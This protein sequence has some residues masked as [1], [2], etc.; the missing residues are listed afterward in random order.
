MSEAASLQ[1]EHHG[2]A[3]RRVLAGR[4]RELAMLRACAASARDGSGALAL[5]G[6]EAGVGKTALVE[7]ALCAGPRERPLTILTARAVEAGGSRLGLW[8]DLLEPASSAET[9]PWRSESPAVGDWLASAARRRP[10]AIVLEDLQWADRDSLAMLGRLAARADDLPLLL[11]G[12]YRTDEPAAELSELLPTLVHEAR[13]RRVALRPLDPAELRELVR[14]HRAM[15]DEDESRLVDHLHRRTGGNPLLALEVLHAL[16][17]DGILRETGCGGWE[18]GSLGGESLPAVVRQ[19]VERRV[20]RLGDDARALLPVA[21]VLGREVWLTHWQAVTE[22]SPDV[23]GA[24]IERAT[25][26][27]VLVE[28]GEGPELRFASE[29]VHE[30]LYHGVPLP[31]RRSWHQRAAEILARMPAPPSDLVAHHFRQARDPRAL[32]WFVRGA[33]TAQRARA[34]RDA[35]ARYR[36]A[37][38]LVDHGTVDPGERTRLLVRLG[39]ADHHVDPAAALPVLDECLRRA[40]PDPCRPMA[41]AARYARGVAAAAAGRTPTGVT[42][43]RAVVRALP[44]G[45]DREGRWRDAADCLGPDGSELPAPAARLALVLATAGAHAEA[46][47]LAEHLGEGAGASSPRSRADAE[48][49]RAEIAAARGHPGPAGRGY[50]EAARLRLDAGDW[51]GAA[52]AMLHGLWHLGLLYYADRPGLA[53]CS[54]A[55]AEATLARVEPAAGAVPPRFAHLPL[56]VISGAWQQAIELAPLGTARGSVFAE[57]GLLAQAAMAAARGEPA[58]AWAVVQE[59]LPDGVETEPGEAPALLAVRALGLGAGLALEA[60]DTIVA[61]EWI[62][63][64]DRWVRAIGLTPGLAEGHLLWARHHR[65]S[66]ELDQ[67]MHH[68]RQACARAA[69]PR[70]PLALLAAHRLVGELETAAGAMDRALHHLDHALALATAC[71]AGYER[72]L[73]QVALAEAHLAMREPGPGAGAK[74]ARAL[75][76]EVETTGAA[77]GARPL[78][79]RARRLGLDAPWLPGSLSSLTTREV[80]VLRLIT[81]GRSNADAA[82]SLGI[83]RR[84]VEHHLEAIYGKLG[85]TSRTAAVREAVAHGLA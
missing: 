52:E 81:D 13:A 73:T 49:A 1:E 68:A 84:T 48:L 57:V 72:A 53:G 14:Q 3:A 51:A 62:Q 33:E 29:L 34:W 78:L 4:R 71:E 19:L 58:Q 12:T 85:V 76:A 82:R 70:Q 42:D 22:A 60:R 80:Q 50:R 54:A 41:L 32:T 43:L 16:E 27:R 45:G 35:G 30:V 39:W 47:A 64:H 17:A 2:A 24:V 79:T 8:R 75:V 31:C 6:G 10:L 9:P 63:A 59:L 37:I 38:D 28:N 61:L 15:A 66:G 67:A 21:A 46:G 5:V 25:A 11:V 56:L 69:Q 20:A 77:L 23:M 65:A 7:A 40:G 55:R 18:L 36:A 74:A 44:D 26:A 83:S